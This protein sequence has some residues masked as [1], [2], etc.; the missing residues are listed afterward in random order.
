[1]ALSTLK[2]STSPHLSQ[3]GLG[4]TAPTYITS[5]TWNPG[6]MGNDLRQIADEFSRIEREYEGAVDLSVFRDAGFGRYDTL[7]VRF[8][9]SVGLDETSLQDFWL[10]PR[11]SFSI[12]IVEIGSV[13]RPSCPPRPQTG[14]FVVLSYSVMTGV[15]RTSL[16]IENLCWSQTNAA[17]CHRLVY[18]ETVFLL[19]T[20]CYLVHSGGSGR[21]TSTLSDR[22]ISDISCGG[23]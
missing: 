1:M 9:I 6:N 3:I 2:S 10:I 17:Y 14:H 23:V 13:D 22:P 11:R 16:R 12:G 5:E 8:F 4:F 18:F 20:R 19:S 7:N 15:G 21:C